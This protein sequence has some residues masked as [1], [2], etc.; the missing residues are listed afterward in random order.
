MLAEIIGI[1]SIDDGIEIAIPRDLS[2]AGPQLGLTEVA[3][4]GR[5]SEVAWIRELAGLHLEQWHVEVPG[6]PDRGAPLHL[7]IRGTSADDRE[8]AVDAESPP[9]HDRQQRGVDPTRIAE[10]HPSESEQ[11]A[12]QDVEG[13]HGQ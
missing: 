6:K 3:P 5:V 13:R 9:P 8:E 10:Q 4:V 1:G 11:M 2:E 12:T 7:R